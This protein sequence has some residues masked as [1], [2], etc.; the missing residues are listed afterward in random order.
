MSSIVNV[1]HTNIIGPIRE[2]LLEPKKISVLYQK[3]EAVLNK[4]K[5]SFSVFAH[6]KQLGSTTL[7]EN[8]ELRRTVGVNCY[9]FAIG[10]VP[11]AT[12]SPAD[13]IPGGAFVQQIRQSL[14]RIITEDVD[15][16]SIVKHFPFFKNRV[17]NKKTTATKLKEIFLYLDI[18]SEHFINKDQKPF[19]LFRDLMEMVLKEDK[20]QILV[21]FIKSYFF[22]KEIGAVLSSEEDLK[23]LKNLLLN[24]YQIIPERITPQVMS[25]L[26][27]L[28][29]LFMVYPEMRGIEEEEK[30]ETLDDH[31]DSRVVDFGSSLIA[32]FCKK[33]DDYHFLRLFSD[34]WYERD[35]QG[36]NVRKCA[37]ISGDIPMGSV[38]EIRN[39]FYKKSEKDFVGYFIVPTNINVVDG[40]GRKFIFES[41]KVVA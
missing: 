32:A 25:N 27:K 13:P 6:S 9:A 39:V 37:N 12:K 16:T 3:V 26:L 14:Y 33:N 1:Q 34:G 10:K 24:D 20:H 5:I 36:N 35:R 15:S 28:D 29:G 7:V 23:E 11:E 41:H 40:L 8:I 17:F 21:R 18:L 19:L 2:E 38:E 31:K 30:K 4:Q 22:S